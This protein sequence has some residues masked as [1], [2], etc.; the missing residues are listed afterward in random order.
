MKNYSI[1]FVVVAMLLAQNAGAVDLG[2]GFSL[3]GFGTAG[4]VYNDN[5][6][7]DFAPESTLAA[8]GAGRTNSLTYTVDTKAAA[9]L[10]WQASPRLSLTAQMLV[11]QFPDRSWDPDLQWAFAKYKAT[12]DL[13][14]RL[15]RIRPPIYMLSDSLD[16]NY[17]NPWVRPP[18]EF[19]SLTP[20]RRME[21][22]DLLWRPRTGSVTWLIQPYI[23]RSQ[24]EVRG[25]EIGLDQI[26][27][28]NA[29]ASLGDWTLR[30]GYIHTRLSITSRFMDLAFGAYHPLCSLG[31]VTACAPMKKLDHTDREA[32]FGSIGAS[33]DNGDYFVSGEWGRRDTD[34]SIANLMSW[35][36]TSGARLGRWTP[37][38]TYSEM[39][40]D[41][42]LDYASGSPTTNYI[43]TGLLRGNP[44]DQRTF[45]M[46]VRLDLIEN[47]A[48]KAQ[49]DHTMTD[50]ITHPDPWNG[51]LPGTCGG[52][53]ILATDAFT[54]KAQNLDLLSLSVDFVF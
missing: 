47:L 29:A 23:G 14:L 13:D 6:E 25:G 35:Y 32:S 30:A 37:F 15:G 16:L 54:R 11:K 34:T 42:P 1:L 17:A 39:Q 46:G 45:T 21:G 12:P 33:W 27:G 36:L 2:R 19:Y 3:K 22:G 38:F 8:S 43:T 53:F 20:I 40:S 51:L 52:W 31:D 9:Q 4:L 18:V 7:A 28:I 50:C 5:R 10:D 26:L 44:T 41:S 48:I 49:W 24:T